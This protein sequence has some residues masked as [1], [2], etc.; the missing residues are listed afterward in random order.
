M[1][2]K[3]N[4]RKRRLLVDAIEL[5]LRF[6]VH[7]AVSQDHDAIKQAPGGIK[8][9]CSR[10]EYLWADGAYT[11]EFIDWALKTP[12]HHSPHRRPRYH[13]LMTSG[14]QRGVACH[15]WLTPK[16]LAGHA[17]GGEYLGYSCETSATTKRQPKRT[18]ASFGEAR[19]TRYL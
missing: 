5:L 11:G 17:A 4:E 13:R 14:T 16:S 6:V 15:Q 7:A 2:N 12:R 3:V 1:G 9:R 18:T 8:K 10:L 19:R